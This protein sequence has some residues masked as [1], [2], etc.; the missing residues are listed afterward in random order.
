MSVDDGAR[1][2]NNWLDR[3]LRGK[4]GTGRR[5]LSFPCA[6]PSSND[7]SVLLLSQTNIVSYMPKEEMSVISYTFVFVSAITV[8]SIVCNFF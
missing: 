6:F 5:V 3:W 1:K 8:N 2:S 4:L 7:V